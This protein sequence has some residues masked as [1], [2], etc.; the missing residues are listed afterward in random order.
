MERDILCNN[1][2]R[3]VKFHV[4]DMSHKYLPSKSL[5]EDRPSFRLVNF[6]AVIPF[7]SPIKHALIAVIRASHSVEVIQNADF[8]DELVISFFSNDPAE[9][10]K[11]LTF[12]RNVLPS[13]GMNVSK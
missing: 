6:S 13:S 12:R 9:R 8:S 5:A 7:I 2:E 3:K 11:L 4:M 10:L 1:R